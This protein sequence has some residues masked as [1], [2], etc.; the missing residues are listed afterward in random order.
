MVSATI[1]TGQMVYDLIV[2]A[3]PDETLS[4]G[5]L[6]QGE[7]TTPE[8][9]QTFID[10]RHGAI[11]SANGP[12]GELTGMIAMSYY[13][14]PFPFEK[15]KGFRKIGWRREHIAP[16]FFLYWFAVHPDYQGR[17]IGGRLLDA[18]IAQC[19]DHRAKALRGEGTLN[20]RA[21][22]AL[23]LKKQAPR[24]YR[25]F[26]NRKFVPVL[27]YEPDSNGLNYLMQRVLH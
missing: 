13:S 1:I 23:V 26:H 5:W 27:A 20:A 12:D 4:E 11:V 16:M 3:Y 24:S 15:Q 7:P 8:F 14:A 17:G 21:I 9:F 10:K 18:T 2:K 19:V 22:S 6:T 25:A